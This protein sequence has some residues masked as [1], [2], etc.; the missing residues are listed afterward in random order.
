MSLIDKLLRRK[1]PACNG[2]GRYQR[3]NVDSEG[4]ITI[5]TMYCEDCRGTG[6]RTP[7]EDMDDF[8]LAGV[9]VTEGDDESY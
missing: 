4:M 2:V 9:G 6:Q 1:C 3:R 8:D 7:L 5:E